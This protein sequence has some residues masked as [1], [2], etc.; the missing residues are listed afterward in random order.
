MALQ[1]AVY[2]PRDAE[3]TVLHQVIAE[4]LE[5]FLDA[6]AEAG[7][8]AGLPQF[9]GRDRGTYRLYRIPAKGGD[10]PSPIIAGTRC[11]LGFSVARET[12]HIAFTAT[13]PVSPAELFVLDP[14]GGERRLTDLNR[15]WK[16]EV[17]LSRPERF[18]F[19]RAGYDIDA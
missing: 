10:V 12:V 18:T 17:E 6:V 5:A 16:A 13:D 9:V 8:G 7:D 4:H 19:H 3:H 14:D 11:V 15:E 2:R 1:R